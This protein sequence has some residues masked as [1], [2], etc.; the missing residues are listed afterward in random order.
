MS[1]LWASNLKMV[2]KKFRADGKY[3]KTSWRDATLI[4]DKLFNEYEK[5]YG[6]ELEGPAPKIKKAKKQNPRKIWYNVGEPPAGF[7]AATMIQAAEKNKIFRYG[8]YKVDGKILALVKG[9][10]IKKKKKKEDAAILPKVVNPTPVP[11]VPKAPAVPKQPKVKKQ[12]DWEVSATYARLLIDDL[13]VAIAGLHG[14]MKRTNRLLDEAKHDHDDDEIKVQKTKLNTLRQK[15]IKALMKILMYKKQP[16]DPKL[17]QELK[18]LR[19]KNKER[20]RKV[21]IIDNNKYANESKQAKMDRLKIELSGLAGSLRKE[22]RLLEDAD[23]R[24]TEEAQ[25]RKIKR[26]EDNMTIIRDELKKLL[27]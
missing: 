20:Q 5:K 11:K 15:E 18:D 3:L 2:L 4:K 27:V 25:K 7:T 16:K 12:K 19:K 1:G 10:D 24:G 8:Q 17:E 9:E 22:K 6:V 14:Q 21:I 26:I 13:R 23:Y